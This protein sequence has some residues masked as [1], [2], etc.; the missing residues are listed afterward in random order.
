MDSFDLSV[1]S[2][3]FPSLYAYTGDHADIGNSEDLSRDEDISY[4]IG[5][6]VTWLVA[7]IRRLDAEN[8][9]L[10]A[11]LREIRDTKGDYDGYRV[12]EIARRVLD[13]TEAS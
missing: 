6:H 4:G 1:F 2:P 5:S 8:E 9:R 11:G 10:R 3:P 7:E 13:E 12:Y